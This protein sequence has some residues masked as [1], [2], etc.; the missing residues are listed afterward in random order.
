M[1]LTKGILSV[2]PPGAARKAEYPPVPGEFYHIP[3]PGF[4]SL[5]GFSY[6][7]SREYQDIDFPK[8]EGE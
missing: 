3:I 2:Y 8:L 4:P 7:T 1:L 5:P 6:L